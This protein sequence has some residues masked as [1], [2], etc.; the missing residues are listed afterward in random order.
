MPK[1]LNAIGLLYQAANETD[2]KLFKAHISPYWRIWRERYQHEADLN[3]VPAAILLGAV[4]YLGYEVP[5]PLK[6]T[7]R[8]PQTALA[9]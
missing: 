7:V 2:Q 5:T 4:F 3:L 8:K 6:Q 1:P 9:R